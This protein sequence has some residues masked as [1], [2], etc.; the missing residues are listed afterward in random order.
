MNY[1]NVLYKRKRNKIVKE[2]MKELK[3]TLKDINQYIPFDEVQKPMEKA[4][5]R[6]LKR[7]KRNYDFKR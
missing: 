6:D 4:I 5:I 3:L 1:K 7:S 2:V